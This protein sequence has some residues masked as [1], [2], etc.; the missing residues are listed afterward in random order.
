MAELTDKRNPKLPPPLP[1]MS[2]KEQIDNWEE[3]KFTED[4]CKQHHSCSCM[5]DNMLELQKL[6]FSYEKEIQT[7]KDQLNLFTVSIKRR[8]RSE[9]SKGIPKS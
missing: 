7:L 1:T 2:K 5:M 4:I 6:L 3:K 8:S 9:N